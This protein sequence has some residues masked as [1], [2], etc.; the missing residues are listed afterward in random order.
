M[1][2]RMLVLLVLLAGTTAFAETRVR[3]GVHI[4]DGYP[5]GYYAPP[6]PPP[7]V[8]YTP[9]CPGP[10]YYWVPG[11]YYRVGPRYSWRAGYWAPPRHHHKH[12]G[13]RGRYEFRGRYD[14]DDDRYD[15]YDRRSRYGRYRDE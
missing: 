10:D 4:G 6:P 12:H 8:V 5:Y 7:V 13:Y 14:D 9:P 11:A 1:K 15:R 3:I 2:T